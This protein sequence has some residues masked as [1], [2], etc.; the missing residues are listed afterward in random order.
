[1]L[2][3]FCFL[4]VLFSC[5]VLSQ[6]TDPLEIY[7]TFPECRDT[8]SSQKEICF[9]RTLHQFIFDHFNMP[10]SIS[11]KEAG[12]VSVLFEVSRDGDFKI[13]YIDGKYQEVK[14]EISRVFDLLPQIEP[15]TYNGRPQ[16]MQFRFS[17]ELPIQPPGT[18]NH[19]EAIQEVSSRSLSGEYDEVKKLPYENDKYESQIN[20]P[21]S[22]HYYSLFDPALNRVGLNNHTAQKPYTYSEVNKYYDFEREEI[23]LFKNKSSWFGRKFWNEHMV[24]VKGEDY[25]FTLDPGVDLQLGTDFSEDINT[26]NNTRIAFVQGGIG[27]QFNFHAVIYESQ[28]RFAGY[29]N[30]YA[31]SIP[32]A[33]GNP[34]IIPGQGPAK[35][36]GSDAYDYP[37]ATGYISYTPSKFF[38]LQFGHGKTFTGDG[39]RSLFMSDNASSYPFFK[40]NTTFWKLKYTNT[41]MSMRDVRRDVAAQGS[42]KPKYMA[43]HYLS[44]N[45]TKRLNVGLFEAVVWENDSGR[46]FDMNF[47]NPIIFY[48]AIEFGTGGR[49]GNAFIGLAGKY[50]FSDKVNLYG[51]FAIDEFSTKAVFKGEGSFQNKTGYQIGLK[52]YDAFNIN[53]LYLQAEY[54][55]VRPYTYSHNT[56]LL[57]FGHINQPVAHTF[58]ANFSEFIAVARYQ[59]GRIFGDAKLVFAQRGFDFNTAE[60]SL[61][62]G[63]DIY[64]SEYEE[65]PGETGN[66]VGQG[67]KTNFFHTELQLGYLINPS[68]NLKIY[69]SLIYRN[70]NPLMDTDLIYKSNTTW[71]NFGIRTD[72]FNWYYDF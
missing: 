67:N 9:R 14:D 54:N 51:Q 39:Y 70:I 49:G 33:G 30:R 61:N 29:F 65:M 46:G 42:F 48:R 13:M 2:R 56:V 31:E 36:F 43:S 26:Y 35:R 18:L 4:L 71:I 17:I 53:N 21:F 50:K 55:R 37:V 23:S 69:G 3:R 34:G 12:D 58:G 62:Y 66:F 63:G 52:Y 28:G 16:Y 8:S 20:I 47:L 10:E 38:N 60:D 44:Y 25:W 45:V 32:P 5:S 15:G 1:M 24:I 27:R 57:N 22:H 64:R 11:E 59:S 7:P 40:I 41:W 68:T 19:S 72:L 6:T